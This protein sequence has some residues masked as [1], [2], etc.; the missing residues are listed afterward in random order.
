[1]GVIV[2][3]RG[4]SGSGKT[5]LVRCIASE[6]GWYDGVANPIRREGRKRP[7]AYCLPHPLGYRP[8]VLVGDYTLTSG[9]CD[10]IR[11][12]DGGLDEAFRLADH[13]AAHGCDVLLEGLLLSSE[14]YRSAALAA[15]HQLYIIHLDTPLDRCIRN[16]IAR[17]RAGVSRRLSAARTATMHYPNIEETCRRLQDHATVERLDFDGALRRARHLLGLDRSASR[18]R[19]LSRRAEKATG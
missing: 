7:I 6:Y 3:P 10:T 12:A 18:L 17:Q 4:T 13:Y 2:N 16:V 1:V 19:T 15:L 8:L 14:H 11:L 5:E 9:G